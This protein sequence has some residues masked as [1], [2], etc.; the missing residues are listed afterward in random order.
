MNFKNFRTPLMTIIKFLKCARQLK[1]KI[2]E[3][4]FH[5]FQTTLEILSELFIIFPRNLT[6]KF[7]KSVLS[8]YVQ[9]RAFL[10]KKRAVF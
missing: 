3:N 7:N 6:S 2:I 9:R 5:F 10:F 1:Q 8:K 4:R